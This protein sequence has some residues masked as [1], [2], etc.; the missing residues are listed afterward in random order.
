MG[1]HT[2][3]QQNE[4][5]GAKH[6]GKQF[7]GNAFF[8]LHEYYPPVLCCRKTIVADVT[9]TSREAMGKFDCYVPSINPPSSPIPLTVANTFVDP[10]DKAA[11]AGWRRASVGEC[12]Q[13]SSAGIQQ[14]C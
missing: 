2:I 11:G 1:H 3:T 9:S 4:D 5:E 13:E 10:H 6:L 14:S 8:S 12:A 7:A